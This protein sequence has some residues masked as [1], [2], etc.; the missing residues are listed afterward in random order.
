MRQHT[1]Q[2]NAS[3]LIKSSGKWWA[4]LDL[5]LRPLPCEGRA[6]LTNS[7]EPFKKQTP[8]PRKRT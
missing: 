6:L 3:L 2:R 5:N 8:T 4:R 7:P 1:S